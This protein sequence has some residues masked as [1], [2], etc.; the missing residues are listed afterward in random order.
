LIHTGL[1]G[2][3]ASNMTQSAGGF[4]VNEHF[5]TKLIGK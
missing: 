4:T 1:K 2:I 3:P 5:S